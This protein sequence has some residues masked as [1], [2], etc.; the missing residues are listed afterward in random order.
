M[1]VESSG[2]A[3]WIRR[4]AAN[5]RRRS[6]VVG[7]V[8]CIAFAALL[9]IAL[10]SFP[11]AWRSRIAPSMPSVP[12]PDT[13]AIAQAIAQATTRLETAK[14]SLAHARAIAARHAHPPQPIDTF[15]APVRARRDTLD[16][17]LA[18]LG[19][20]LQ[21]AESAPLPASY[22]ALGESPV[23]HADPRVRNLLD[24]LA[25]VEQA[26]SAFDPIGGVDPVFLALTT[27]ASDLGKTMQ[28]IAIDKYSVLR[29][30]LAAI[31][32][33]VPHVEPIVVPDTIP[34]LAERDSATA[35]QTGAMHRLAEARV[36][37]RELDDEAAR[38]RERA[39]MGV[40][41]AVLLTAAAVL[42][43]V[44]GFAV[45]LTLELRRPCVADAR[46]AEEI[47]GH[48]VL[49]IVQPHR[50][51]PER[52]RRRADREMPPLIHPVSDTYQAL[53]AQLA[54]S[55]FNL[56]LVGVVGDRPLATAAVAANLAA[57]AARQP[58]ATL[59]VDTDIETHTLSAV[60]HVPSAPG[61][62]DVLDERIEWPET[63]AAMIAGRDRTVDILPSGLG[64]AGS[65][66]L[67]GALVVFRAELAH[68]ARRYETVVVNVAAARGGHPN[69]LASAVQQAV[70]CVCVGR[71]RL[72]T[73]A[74]LVARLDAQGVAIRGL[75]LWEMAEPAQS[76]AGDASP[77]VTVHAAPQAALVR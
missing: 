27:R 70:L 18:Q 2:R 14:Q 19:T 44:M 58:R 13:L 9:G 72:D 74:T 68:L 36:L 48:R 67:D 61:L 64:F 24:S 38:E 56:P 34:L 12:R 15:P 25:V 53:F 33:V 29:T 49:V 41:P 77:L 35:A 63:I 55:A 51:I 28:A 20:L 31:S 4:R 62:T 75:V 1:R 5:V 8:A 47:V 66:A 23:M 39:A 73:L 6:N 16:Q 52:T 59:L 3:V 11:G 7:G 30:Q 17:E 37:V 32:P 54:D 50:A 76:A 60:A 57:T 40:P 26:R 22:R 71:T 65:D 45:A 46:E 43:L 69:A 10:V 21:S 42:A